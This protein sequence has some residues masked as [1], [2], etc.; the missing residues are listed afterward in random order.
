MKQFLR[1]AFYRRFGLAPDPEFV[2]LHPGGG[3][4]GVRLHRYDTLPE[5]VQR[6]RALGAGPE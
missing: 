4:L 6:L 1:V 3:A 5:L 2:E